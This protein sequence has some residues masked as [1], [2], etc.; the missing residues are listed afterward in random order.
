MFQTTNQFPLLKLPISYLNHL[1]STLSEPWNLAELVRTSWDDSTSSNSFLEIRPSSERQSPVVPGGKF[2][3]LWWG[4]LA[5]VECVAHVFQRFFE[6]QGVISHRCACPSLFSK[7][8]R[9]SR[10]EQIDRILGFHNFT[11]RIWERIQLCRSINWSHAPLKTA[12]NAVAAILTNR[13][14]G[15]AYHIQD[16]S[17]RA[18]TGYTSNFYGFIWYSTSNLPESAIDNSKT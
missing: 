4:Q 2:G 10:W 13:F 14:I 17:F 6:K 16:L 9:N 15:G 5:V 8:R 3:G 11:D 7:I 18:V 12:A 1:K